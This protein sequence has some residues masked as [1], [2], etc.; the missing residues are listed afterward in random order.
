[1]DNPYQRLAERLN[2]IPNGYPATPEGL[3]LEILRRIFTPEEAALAA[4]LKLTLETASQVAERLGRDPGE[5]RALLKTMVRKGLIDTRPLEKELGFRLMPFIVGIYE[6]QVGNLDRE[7]AEVFERYYKQA[8]G[9]ALS[10][11]P[12]IHR[13]VP[14]G[15]SVKVDMEIRP[16]ESVAD[17]VAG[18]KAWG[19]LDC[20][21]RKQ[22][23]LLGQAC[24]HPIDVCM[25]LSAM[26]NY[27][28]HNPVIRAVSQ[29]EA[30]DTLRRAAQAGLVHSLS[31]YQRGLWYICNC[32]TCSCGILRGISELGMANAVA[33]SAFI[34][35]VDTD[36]CQGCE[37][38]V[39]HCPF[40]A[41]RMADRLA[42][43][44]D[45]RCL[46]C[47]VCAAACPDGALALVRR[48]TAEAEIPMGS[49]KDWMIARATQRGMDLS[50]LL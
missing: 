46:G 22:K 43:V 39:D 47:G 28:D 4:Q 35:Q 38:C 45:G 31:N 8:L 33:R 16:Y 12:P 11:Q 29:D 23:S 27:F 32:C 19:V 5:T 18:A 2:T 1:M 26:P 15:A 36:L 50:E 20:I 14:I 10:M 25:G 6:A 37:L 7:L 9:A 3:E 44:D 48:P 30:M 49:I 21:C 41:L 40:H 42:Q 17:L 24:G 34:N 13:V